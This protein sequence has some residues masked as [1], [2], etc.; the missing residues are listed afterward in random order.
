MKARS[1]LFDYMRMSGSGPLDALNFVNATF[2]DPVEYF[3]K[4]ISKEKLIEDKRAYMARWPERMYQLKPESVFVKC[5]AAAWSC[6]VGGEFYFRA[7]NGS[8]ISNGTAVNR[9]VVN[10]FD[11]GPRI[12][13]ENGNVTSRGLEQPHPTPAY[14]GASPAD[15]PPYP[16]D[17][18]PTGVSQQQNG[19]PPEQARQLINGI[20][21][22]VI[23][24][25]GR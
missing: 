12:L 6:E 25:M 8:R 18:R 21:G 5:D 1:F 20:F 23:R 22:T 13:S 14:Q 24:Q 2:A 10:F 9:L 19:I 3:G 4:R 7:A 17:G 16:I 11:G 15:V